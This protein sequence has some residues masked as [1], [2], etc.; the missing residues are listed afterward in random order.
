MTEKKLHLGCGRCYLPPDEGW[1]NVDIFSNVH[2][3]AYH[4]VT[5]L[6]FEKKSFSLVYA[7]HILEHVHRHMILSTLC[8]WR[9]LLK[10]G[11][12]LR[13]A[14]PDFRAV[15]ARYGETD[16]LEELLGL[17]YGGQNLKLNSHTITFDSRTLTKLLTQAGFRDVR[18]WDWR[19]TEHAD[20]DDYSRA[21]LPHLDFEK[22]QAMSLNLEATS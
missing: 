8:H 16:N 1:T 6:P 10:E 13:L 17:L 7:S 9:G 4:S 22:G 20:Y 19:K 2:A 14:V 5:D 11:G 21:V 18:W 3:D 12:T 15:C